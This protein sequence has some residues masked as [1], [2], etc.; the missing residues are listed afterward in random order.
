MTI[1]NF[2]DT[3]HGKLFISDI[4]PRH[5][6][7]A[8]AAHL[9]AAAHRL[10]ST[11]LHNRLTYTRKWNKAI[12]MWTWLHKKANLQPGWIKIKI[13]SKQIWFVLCNLN[14]CKISI[15]IVTTRFYLVFQLKQVKT[16]INQ[17]SHWNN[18]MCKFT[19]LQ[20]KIVKIQESLS[21]CYLKL[22]ISN[23]LNIVSPQIHC[24]IQ[25]FNNPTAKLIE[26]HF[27]NSINDCI[28]SD[29]E[30]KANFNWRFLA[31]MI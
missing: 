20:C 10:G 29:W 5:T 8:L 22:I 13:F 7:T 26:N 14:F 12:C 27:R 18:C 1:D 16:A 21:I 19:K 4:L 24:H 11:G 2:I 15:E 3:S 31:I 25:C 17:E 9:C 23:M 30:I 28:C 6:S